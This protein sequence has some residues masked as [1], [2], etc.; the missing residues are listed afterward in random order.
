MNLS[1]KERQM[2]GDSRWAPIITGRESMATA[3]VGPPGV[4]TEASAENTTTAAVAVA[5]IIT[6]AA[7]VAAITAATAALVVRLIPLPGYNGDSIADRNA[8]ATW[9]PT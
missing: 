6:A 1:A 8:P 9:K 3:A 4:I 7:V 2:K 5:G